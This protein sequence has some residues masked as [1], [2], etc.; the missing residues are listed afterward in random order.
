GDAVLFY[1]LIISSWIGYHASVKALPIKGVGRFFVDIVLLFSYSLALANL[2]SFIITSFII[3]A[4]FALYFVCGMIC[5]FEYSDKKIRTQYQMIERTALSGAFA[6][7]FLIVAI[8]V[9]LNTDPTVQGIFLSIS[10][11]LIVSYRI[12]L[13]TKLKW[14]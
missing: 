6:T 13:A 4:V 7:L 12:M 14:P 10:F 1:G 11:V 3:S 9:Y 8:L 2:K 5:F